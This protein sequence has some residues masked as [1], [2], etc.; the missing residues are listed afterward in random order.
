MGNLGE[1]ELQ[2]ER[3]LLD[4]KGRKGL[5]AKLEAPGKRDQKEEKEKRGRLVQL[6]LKVLLADLET[7]A[8]L[9]AQV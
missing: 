8:K 3:A 9:D 7:E 5:T 1:K 2:E 6:D 4:H